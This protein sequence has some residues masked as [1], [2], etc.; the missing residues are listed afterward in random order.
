M[1]TRERQYTLDDQWHEI[2]VQF[3]R[4]KGDVVR[5]DKKLLEFISEASGVTVPEDVY[6]GGT[7]AKVLSFKRTPFFE[8][9]LRAADVLIEQEREARKAKT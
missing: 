3:H 5:I 6:I 8:Y 9:L 2:W 7:R 4:A 1:P